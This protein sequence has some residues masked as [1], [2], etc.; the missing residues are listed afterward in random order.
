L[1]HRKIIALRAD[2][3]GANKSPKTVGISHAL[4]AALPAGSCRRLAP[5]L[6][7]NIIVRENKWINSI[8]MPTAEFIAERAQ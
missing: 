2:S 8:L 1:H 5:P 3:H 7:V 4:K 6:D